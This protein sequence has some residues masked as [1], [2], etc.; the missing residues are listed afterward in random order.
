MSL[1]V[2][3]ESVQAEIKLVY[4]LLSLSL[5]FP[6]RQNSKDMVGVGREKDTYPWMPVIKIHWDLTQRQL[7]TGREMT[8]TL[9]SPLGTICSG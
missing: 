3:Y 5:P 8:N 7:H 1:D 6:Q 9:Q 2:I 4:F